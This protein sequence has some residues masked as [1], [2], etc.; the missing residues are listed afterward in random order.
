MNPLFKMAESCKPHVI[1]AY[2]PNVV[3]PIGEHCFVIVAHRRNLALDAPHH[4][5]IHL[6]F[7]AH[8]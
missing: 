8:S 6:S 2:G 5:M 1:I 3:E 7:I 4:H